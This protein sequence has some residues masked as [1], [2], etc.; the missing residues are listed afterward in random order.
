MGHALRDEPHLHAAK[1]AG[2]HQMVDVPQIADADDLAFQVSQ[3]SAERH[4]EPRNYAV[5]LL[6]PDL[7]PDACKAL[8]EPRMPVAGSP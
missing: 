5:L 6:N 2:Q 7:L 3:A 1:R 4:V 8:R